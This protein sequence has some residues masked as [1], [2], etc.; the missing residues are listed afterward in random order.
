MNEKRARVSFSATSQHVSTIPKALLAWEIIMAALLAT[1]RLNMA[2]VCKEWEKLTRRATRHVGIAYHLYSPERNNFFRR[3]TDWKA[4]L[5]RA[6]VK[7][8]FSSRV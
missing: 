3:H 7:N 1:D 8:L 5:P 6:Q 2:L 4:Y